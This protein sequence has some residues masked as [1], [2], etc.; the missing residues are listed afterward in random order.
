MRFIRLFIVVGAL[1]CPGFVRGQSNLV[2]LVSSPGDFIGQGRI[3]LTEDP[4]QFSISGTAIDAFG[5][6]FVFAGPGGAPLTVGT[7][8]DA[9]RWPFNGASP[10]IDISG[11]GRGCNY[12]CGSFEVFEIHT[13]SSGQVDRLWLVFTNSCICTMTQMTGEVRYNSQMA[14]PIPIQIPKTIRV[15]ADFTTIQAAI[16]AANIFTNDTVLV[17]PGV[18]TESLNFYGKSLLLISANGPME[19]LINPPAGSSAITFSTGESSNS[20]VSGFTMTNGGIS[21]SF[22]APTI[23]SNKFVNCGTAVYGYF[24]SPNIMDNEI[25]GCVNNGIYLGG[26][27]TAVVQG[28]LILGNGEGIAMLSSGSASIV[29]NRIQNNHGDGIGMDNYCDANI[30]Q[31][32]ITDNTGDGIYAAGIGG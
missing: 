8:T 1:L 27:G 30:L 15:P 31:N 23:I 3:Y 4:S 5:F 28:N 14:P 11:N 29:D 18:Y 32:I 22:S 25:S 6:E 24:S 26:A 10:G 9:T 2:M 13:N 21:L 19:T 12:E 16:N 7:Y 17:S 20:I